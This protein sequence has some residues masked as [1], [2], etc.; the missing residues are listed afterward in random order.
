[1]S[2]MYPRCSHFVTKFRQTTTD[3]PDHGFGMGHTKISPG[4]SNFP[5][6]GFPD[7]CRAAPAPTLFGGPHARETGLKFARK[8]LDQL[9]NVLLLDIMISCQRA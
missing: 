8:F 1:M 7:V 4:D 6:L 3:E 5:T 2:S 9:V